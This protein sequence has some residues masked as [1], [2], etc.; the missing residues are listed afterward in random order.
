MTESPKPAK[1]G[2]KLKTAKKLE[3]TTTL[4]VI[5]PFQ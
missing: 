4:T 1:K 2:K 5:N 3:R